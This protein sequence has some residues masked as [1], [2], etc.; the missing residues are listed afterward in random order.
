[1]YKPFVSFVLITHN[2][3][4]TIRKNLLSIQAQSYNKKEIIA[5]DDGSGDGTINVLENF[6]VRVIKIPPCPAAKALNVGFRS[7]KGDII[8]Y[9][10]A[11]AYLESKNWLDSVIQAFKKFKPDAVITNMIPKNAYTNP[12]AYYCAMGPLSISTKGSFWYKE[13][14]GFLCN[15]SF[16]KES[17][18][19]VGFANEHFRVAEDTELLH[20]FRKKKKKILHLSSVRV[21][22]D[23]DFGFRNLCKLSWK[24]GKSRGAFYKLHPDFRTLRSKIKL[25]FILGILVAF[26]C[27]LFYFPFLNLL[28][29]ISLFGYEINRVAEAKKHFGF[30]NFLQIIFYAAVDDGLRFFAFLTGAIF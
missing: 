17:L 1:M 20:R 23:H 16:L 11:D 22:H 10:G 26:M 4:R 19:E 2:N 9:L 6:N 12:Y 14:T 18:Q 28:M 8:C 15:C 30:L 29:L 7:A 3:I 21:I 27:S 13:T 25:F 5:V 24:Q